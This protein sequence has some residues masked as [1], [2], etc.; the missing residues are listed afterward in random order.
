MVVKLIAHTPDPELIVA[1]AAKLCYS[2]SDVTSLLDGQ[3]DEEVEAF[4]NKLMAM[5]HE[6]PLEHA[7]FTF[8]IEDVSRS[9]LA[10]ITRH[11]IASYSVQSQ[12]YVNMQRSR[13]V[14]PPVIEK[15][16][17]IFTLYARASQV[18]FLAYGEILHMIIEKYISQGM[19]EKA[20]AK[21]AQ[22]DARFILPNSCGTRLIM[23]MNAR[24]LLN[25]FKLRCCNRAQWEIRQLADAMLKL[26]K[27][28]APNLFKYAGPSCVT[29]KCGEGRM[30]CGKPRKEELTS[31]VQ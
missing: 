16:E 22:E 5:G 26:A 20:A 31:D 12:R 4:I 3:T 8:A 18:S 17:K 25:F 14:V 7:V 9:L 1:T 29:G 28:A 15:D 11:R 2:E 10:Q 30:S 24:S 6:S 13:Y 21:K 27:Q 23:T 19:D